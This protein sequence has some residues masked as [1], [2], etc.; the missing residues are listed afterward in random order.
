MAWDPDAR[1]FILIFLVAS[2]RHSIFVQTSFELLKLEG[3]L[4]TRMD[5]PHEHFFCHIKYFG[6]DYP[7]SVDMI[8]TF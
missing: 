6:S 5:C 7:E 3:A 2:A 8:S 4:Q 1:P